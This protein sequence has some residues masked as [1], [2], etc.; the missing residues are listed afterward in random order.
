MRLRKLHFAQCPNFVRMCTQVPPRHTK[1]R[2]GW[3][4]LPLD[5]IDEIVTRLKKARRWRRDGPSLRLLNKHWSKQADTHITKMRPDKSRQLTI[6]DAMSLLK[7]Q[8]LS[9]LDISPFLR[10]YHASWGRSLFDILTQLPRLSHIDIRRDFLHFSG[11]YVTAHE[12][13]CIYASWKKLTQVSSLRFYCS[14]DAADARDASQYNG[15]WS[16][17]DNEDHILS[18]INVSAIIVDALPH[19]K[20]LELA[21]WADRIPWFFSKLEKLERLKLL[22]LGPSDFLDDVI[23]WLPP[24]ASLAVGFPYPRGLQVLSDL[25]Q[26]QS[27]VIGSV[28]NI[29]ELV[30]QGFL[31]LLPN[32][33]TLQLKANEVGTSIPT[34]FVTRPLKLNYLSLHKFAFDGKDLLTHL[35]ELKTLKLSLCRIRG[36]TSF[37]AAAKQLQDFYACWVEIERDQDCITDLE[38]ADLVALKNL[39]Y[40]RID[41]IKRDDMMLDLAK[42]SS[43]EDVRIV[44]TGDVSLRGLDALQY[45]PNLRRLGLAHE[46]I[47]GLV[48]PF[49]SQTYLTQLE[50]LDISAFEAADQIKVYTK[51][52]KKKAPNMIINVD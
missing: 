24:Q 36:D 47:L 15:D 43:L 1:E 28:T 19:L 23:H 13:E 38:P 33:L 37:F 31:T 12:M 52:L 29:Q 3:D 22:T 27:L 50:R 14:L 49:F 6:A 17:D 48:R 51:R 10:P 21:I 20:A 25:P 34:G 4:S 39:R 40:L 44:A 5:I 32:L 2:L 46:D 16:H 8:H 35:P 45:L 11:G 7:F 9:T 26:L 18:F 41:G 42:L 30:F